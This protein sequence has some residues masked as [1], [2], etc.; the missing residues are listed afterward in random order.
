M[1]FNLSEKC[2]SDKFSCFITY[3]NNKFISTT[4]Y[5]NDDVFSCSLFLCLC[6]YFQYTWDSRFMAHPSLGPGHLCFNPLRIYNLQHHACYTAGTH[7][8]SKLNG[9]I[10]R[11]YHS[12][13]Y[14]LFCCVEVEF[15]LCTII[16]EAACTFF[17]ESLHLLCNIAL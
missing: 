17:D 3:Y 9:L 13:V 6:S 12:S 7:K 5:S 11:L 8:V 2:I 16:D 1:L 4:L 10:S 15:S 14:P